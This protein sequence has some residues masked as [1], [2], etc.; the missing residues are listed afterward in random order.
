MIFY[1]IAVMGIYGSFGP[2][3]SIPT[4]FLTATAAAGAIAMINSIG[5]LGGFLGPYAM[6]FIRDATGSFTGGVMFLV[7]CMLLAAMLIMLLR[8]TGRDA[9][10]QRQD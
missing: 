6:G 10:I 7:A 1:T 8:K 3:W 9:D 5:N 2:F 4:S